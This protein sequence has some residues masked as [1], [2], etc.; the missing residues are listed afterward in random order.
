M[1]T[2]TT[3]TKMFARRAMMPQRICFERHLID[4][5]IKA[6]NKADPLAPIKD[7]IAKLVQDM[8][9]HRFNVDVPQ[10]GFSHSA[11]NKSIRMNLDSRSV[12]IQGYCTLSFKSCGDAHAWFISWS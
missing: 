2:P 11:S 4:V 6:Q 8:S 12:W 10:S 5:A 9:S 1:K 3:F 7:V